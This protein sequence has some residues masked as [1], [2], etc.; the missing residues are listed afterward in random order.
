[1]ELLN[2]STNQIQAFKTSFEVIDSLVSDTNFEVTPLGIR[3]REINRTSKLFLSV[4]FS[5]DNF[6]IWNYYSGADV[7]N[8][9]IDIT[10]IVNA[11][12]PNLHY[13]VL[14]FSLTS[15]KGNLVLESFERNE[16]K[17]VTFD[18]L[19]PCPNTSGVIEHKVYS[20]S[21]ELSSE[22][23][24]KY[25]KDIN[26]TSNLIKIKLGRKVLSVGSA[27]GNLEYQL[28]GG[29]ISITTDDSSHTNSVECTMNVKYF[30]LSCKCSNISELITIY[31]GDIHD[32]DHFPTVKFN[33]GSLGTLSLSLF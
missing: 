16:K 10:N 14:T 21:V 7:F 2:F 33:L 4:F 5:A 3:I 27:D 29:S 25:A 13:D 28:S 1:M 30:L 32:D 15:S 26:R 6:D 20:H 12:K 18:L 17:C 9:G 11:L 31:I 19:P 24:T 8:V 22:L 23:I